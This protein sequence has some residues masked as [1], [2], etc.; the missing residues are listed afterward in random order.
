MKNF[1]KIFSDL[2]FKIVILGHR[3]N[4]FRYNNF[5]LQNISKLIILLFDLSG[6]K[7]IWYKIC[8]PLPNSNQRPASTISVWLIYS[9]ISAY[10]GTFTF[11]FARYE[12]SI[13]RL[14]VLQNN[15]LMQMGE[16]HWQEVIKDLTNI[17]NKPVPFEPQLFEPFSIYQSLLHD[18]KHIP[19]IDQLKT[20]LRAK[21]REIIGFYF[22][23]MQISPNI[24]DELPDKNFINQRE[25]ATILF[26]NI[27][28][29]NADIS[30]LNI[31]D[32]AYSNDKN[33]FE[34]S[35]FSNSTIVNSEMQKV[36]FLKSKF[37]STNFSNSNLSESNF[38]L[39]NFNKAILVNTNF[40][41]SDFLSA[42]LRFADLQQADFR[43]A[44]LMNADLS[45]TRNIKTAKFEGAIYNSRY[46][47]TYGLMA[48]D[49]M[50]KACLN[51]AEV[52]ACND[53][54]IQLFK[55][56]IL[57]PT[58][59]PRNF[60]PRKYG[61]ID[62]CDIEPFECFFLKSQA[63]Q[64]LEK[65]N[66]VYELIIKPMLHQLIYNNDADDLKIKKED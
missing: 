35:N 38:A 1:S 13:A 12:Y 30:K 63:M 16:D 62:I 22:K 60:N 20:A 57:T 41:K 61:M 2:T 11:A 37:F 6:L 29:K 8:P 49:S 28:N 3:L 36:N 42:D 59:F 65:A 4:R 55:P 14:E 31:Q 15:F 54:G 64:W 46:L 21:K 47:A 52:H 34:Q 56:M 23:N 9:L 58:I 45:Y 26:N 66:A 33:N 25:N 19:T 17:Q 27:K 5:I 48:S 24:T 18:T 32:Y 51:G 39:S 53:A 50:E 43:E 40:F 10:L 44:N 7:Y